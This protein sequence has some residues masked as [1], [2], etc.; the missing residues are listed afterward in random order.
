MVI[1]DAFLETAAEAR[2]LLASRD[3]SRQWNEPSVLDRLTIGELAAHLARA[4]FTVETALAAPLPDSTTPMVTADEYYAHAVGLTRDL[5]D[6]LNRAIRD[7]SRDGAADGL[8]ALLHRLDEAI[9]SVATRFDARDVPPQVAAFNGLVLDLDEYLVTRLVELVV[10]LDDL[11]TS[12]GRPSPDV[13]PVARACVLG[14]LVGVARRR[15]G[16]I[17]VIRALARAERAGQVFPVL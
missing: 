14:C 16:D 8:T 3:V 6:D 5:D 17:E 11:A 10:H 2:A 12:L 4:V 7:R 13:S 9:T 15:H 1:R